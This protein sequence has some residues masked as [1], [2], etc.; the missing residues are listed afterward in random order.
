[1]YSS[2]DNPIA[3]EIWAKQIGLGNSVCTATPSWTR[4]VGIAVIEYV[5]VA[6]SLFQG[7]IDSQ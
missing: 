1:M 4:D 7:S 6:L 5:A 3:V 2:G